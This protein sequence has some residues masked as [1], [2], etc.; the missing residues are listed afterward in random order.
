L[1]QSRKKSCHKKFKLLNASPAF[2]ITPATSFVFTES[3]VRRNVTNKILQIFHPFSYTHWLKIV[4]S[5]PF[6]PY[7][8]TKKGTQIFWPFFSVPKYQFLRLI[9]LNFNVWGCLVCAVERKYQKVHR[10][11]TI[12][13][14]YHFLNC[15]PAVIQVLSAKFWVGKILNIYGIFNQTFLSQCL[16]SLWLVLFVIFSSLG[17]LAIKNNEPNIFLLFLYCWRKSSNYIEQMLMK[18]G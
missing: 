10:I 11:I 7:S 4:S 8:R 6:S 14:A 3:M 16:P 15:F 17:S 13:K 9:K 12:I 18:T 2:L 1:E 5:P